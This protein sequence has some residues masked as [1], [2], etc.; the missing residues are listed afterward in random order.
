VTAGATLPIDDT[1]HDGEVEGRRPSSE[2]VTALCLAWSKD[3][4]ERVGEIA[5]VPGGTPGS[6]T[7]GRSSGPAGDGS[8]RV[9]FGRPRPGRAERT[10]T[11]QAPQ[12]SRDQLR[13][14]GRRGGLRV[15]NVGRCPLLVN[16]LS[17][18]AAELQP[19]DL[20]E[21]KGVALFL[22]TARPWTL[23]APPAGSAAWPDFPFGQADAFGIVGESAAAWE[24]RHR[25]AFVGPRPA[26]VLVRGPSG[27]GK[28]L[29][30]QAIHAL[31]PRA[32]RPI[33]SRNAATIPDGLVDAELF[34]N[35]KSYP[36]PGMAERPGL[37]GEADRSTLFLDEFGELPLAAQSHLL[38]VLDQ[39]EY[40]RLGDARPRHTDLRLIA[41]TNRPESALKEDVLARFRLRVELPDLNQRR[42]DIPLLVRHLLIR[43]GRSDP[44]IALRCFPEG[45]LERPPRLTATLM[46]G[47]LRRRYT[48]HIRELES[49]LWTSLGQ[50]G[51]ALDTWVDLE[52]RT[53]DPPSAGPRA[54]AVGVD[55]LSIPAERV[56]EAL[57]R[58]HGRQAEVIAELGLSSRHVLHR[59]IKRYDLRSGRLGD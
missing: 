14:E 15:Q 6:A 7:L 2:L 32:G 21:L 19:G 13:F 25:V 53:D 59:L 49:L 33:V 54:S 17:T 4:G 26:H 47:L 12:I 28:E 41:A 52:E 43:I 30:A 42:D 9:T 22:C 48:T 55:P 31:S 50:S 45:D 5:L 27:A 57:D 11:L 35:A 24:L 10:S 44:A 46:R 29:V 18:E 8:S 39:G 16:G 23:P 34:G 38:R 58:H 36:N 20:V 56:Q 40:H 51:A 37:I 1:T 3:E